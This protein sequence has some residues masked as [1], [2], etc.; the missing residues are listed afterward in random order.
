MSKNHQALNRARW[1]SVR[2]RTLHRDGWRCQQCGAAGRLEVHHL[3][4]LAEGGAPYDLDNLQT[5]CRPCHFKTFPRKVQPPE[6]QAW[7]D[8]VADLAG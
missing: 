1:G 4:P 6:V 3:V 2:R 5:L 7:L 8:L